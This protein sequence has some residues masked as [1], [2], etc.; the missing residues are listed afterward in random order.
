MSP[1]KSKPVLIAG[2]SA[3]ATSGRNTTLIDLTTV[4]HHSVIDELVQVICNKTHNVDRGF[5]DVAVAYF[6]GKMA[7][8]MRVSLKT[9]DRGEIPVN[10]YALA[11]APSGSG[12]GYSVSIMENEILS[13]FKQ[14][15]MTDTFPVIADQNLWKLAMDRA[16]RD[17]TEEQ[18]EKEKLDKEFKRA[19]A[20]A[21][22]FDS[23]TPAAIKQMRHKLLLSGAGAINFQVDEIGSNLEGSTDVL[24]LFFELYD[25]GQIKQKLTKNTAENERSEE[26]DGKTPANMLL[27]GTPSKL[28]DGGK[29]EQAFYDFLETGLARRTIFGMGHRIKAGD[30]LSSAEMFKRLTDP[31]NEQI[32]LKWN[33]HFVELADPARFGWQITVPDAVSIALIEYKMDC[34]ARAE[35]FP[36]YEDVQKSE[37]SHR[38]YKALKLAGAFAFVDESLTLTTTNLMQAI[39]LVEESGT[40]FQKI[41]RR[42]KAYVKLAKFLADVDT[43]QTHA[44]LVEAL[45][46]YKTGNAA[47]TEM[48]TL[49]TAWGYKNNVII[50]KS[51][52]D[53]I[54]F[55]RGET[56][57]ETKLDKISFSYSNHVA[58]NFLNEIQ[59]FADMEKLVKAPG[60]HWANHHFQGGHRSEEN[61]VPGFNLL[62]LDVDGGTSIATAHKLLKDYTFMTYTT[63]RHT[64]EE[65]RFR[66]I[67]PMNYKLVLT[68]EDYKQFMEH[69]LSWLPFKVDESAN[70]R[71]RKWSCNPNGSIIFNDGILLDILPFV[72][73]TAKNEQYQ[74]NYQSVASMDALERW[75]A[76]RMAVGDRNNQMVKFAFAL[77][78]NGCQYNEVEGRV[79]ALNA[80]LSNP[81]SENEI[82]GTILVSVAKKIQ[83]I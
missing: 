64:N 18:L 13:G 17:A 55:Y 6:L 39:K 40:A 21:F 11:L 71:S 24:N 36:E 10:I 8:S 19:G 61:T 73:K 32:M 41:L 38:Y 68:A 44:D 51:F 60:Y 15:F 66:L 20:L 16:I 54:E 27:F 62:V 74:I 7:A 58:Y 31:M 43:D 49:A 14:R 76:E 45:P 57:E 33:T 48:L 30:K 78:D 81:L 28:L 52:V 22:T 2:L 80:K 29:I 26:L 59:K 50:K 69:V 42:E 4:K 37:M 46:F 25:Q 63:K 70:Q 47:R 79:M 12:K 35:L 5:Y 83:G 77:I 65:N 67:M 75:F 1:A 23:G 56:L 72:P 34:E 82:R 9:K 53:G 3:S